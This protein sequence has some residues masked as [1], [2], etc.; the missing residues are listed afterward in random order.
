[1]LHSSALPRVGQKPTGKVLNFRAARAQ[2]FW[3]AP[4]LDELERLQKVEPVAD[5]EELFGT[6]PGDS[7]DGFEDAIDALRH[8][9]ASTT[10]GGR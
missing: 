7:D 1:M 4:S 8:P 3:N 9:C 5:I 2:P 10:G 6:W